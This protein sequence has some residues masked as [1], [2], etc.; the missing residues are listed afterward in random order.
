MTERMTF[1]NIEQVTRFIDKVNQGDYAMAR[2]K[3]F[4]DVYTDASSKL[5]VWLFNKNGELT[6]R[7]KELEEKLSSQETDEAVDD[8]DEVVVEDSTEEV[9]DVDPDSVVI[10]DAKDTM[11]TCLDSPEEDDRH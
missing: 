4:Q 1:D 9:L 8:V 10:E 3:W 11:P 6:D 2:R 5:L 7:V